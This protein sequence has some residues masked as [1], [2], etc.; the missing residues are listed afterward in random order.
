MV[1]LFATTPSF[2]AVDWAE[3][4]CMEQDVATIQCI[5]PLFRNTVVGVMAIAGVVLFLILVVGG[6]QFMMSGGNPKQMEQAK[7][8][9][10]Y[11]IIGVVIIV[12]SFLI[13]KL[14][15]TFTGVTVD[16]FRLSI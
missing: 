6:F 2:A 16:E 3:S 10:T 4:G 11:A 8:T 9:L 14:I 13:I 1:S 15:Q 5:V 7:N 12:A